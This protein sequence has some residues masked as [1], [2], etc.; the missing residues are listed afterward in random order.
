MLQELQLESEIRALEMEVD[1]QNVFF[2]VT[3]LK[4]V[5][6]FGSFWM[7]YANFADSWDMQKRVQNA[8]HFQVD[9]SGAADGDP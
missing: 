7:C 3:V 5:D 1:I 2:K 6:H 8:K 9:P 4:R